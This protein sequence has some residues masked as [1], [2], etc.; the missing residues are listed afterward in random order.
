[1][2]TF[3]SRKLTD[4]KSILIVIIVLQTVSL[5]HHFQFAGDVIAAAEVWELW[6]NTAARVEDFMQMNKNKL[7]PHSHSKGGHITKI[8]SLV[9]NSPAKDLTRSRSIIT[10]RCFEQHLKWLKSIVSHTVHCK[11]KE[12]HIL[13][14]F[15]TNMFI[16]SKVFVH[17][18]LKHGSLYL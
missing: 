9:L 17:K 6:R 14:C 7:D 2:G 12:F 18:H 1:M 3:V 15:D 10:A 5:G 8:S 16:V 13:E 4:R 11:S